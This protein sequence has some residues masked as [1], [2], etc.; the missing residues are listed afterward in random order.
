MKYHIFLLFVILCLPVYAQNTYSPGYI[1]TAEGDSLRGLIFEK[2]DAEMSRK[3]VFKSHENAEVQKLST[4]S[5]LGF[6]FDSGREFERLT[7]LPKPGKEEDTSFIFAKNMLRGHTDVFVGRYIQIR[8]PE[9]FIRNNFS[10]LTFQ[11]YRSRNA[12]AMNLDGFLRLYHN[13][14]D[15]LQ[16]PQ[17]VRTG[18]KR[19]IRRIAEHN[20]IHSQ[21]FPDTVYKEKLENEW[22]ILAGLPVNYR[23]DA[24]HIRGAVYFSRKRTGRTSK[25]SSI[26]GIIYHHWERKD[27]A[28]IGTHQYGVISDSWQMINVMP[29]G[30]KFQD[31][32]G[33]FRPYGYLGAGVA[34]VR[35]KNISFENSPG[36]VKVSTR[37]VLP[38]LN[39]GIG[40]KMRL[41][42]NFLVTEFTPTR[43]NLFLNV[44]F[45]I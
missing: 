4:R 8:H 2:P 40:L 9:I 5:I 27:V 26:H 33:D 23:K 41:G 13:N 32:Q 18:E 31:A 35:E 16:N 28:I 36:G 45:S 1:V 30:I 34:L 17:A 38:T 20:K 22:T 37:E 10:N 12:N 29:V 11:I 3:I 19:L 24:S 25:I 43:N 21:N 39:M 15:S 7:L 14:P 42:K 44:G 6:G